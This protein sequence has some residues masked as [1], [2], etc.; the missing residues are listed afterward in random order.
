MP[1]QQPQVDWSK[2]KPVAAPDVDWSKAAPVNASPESHPPGYETMRDIVQGIPHALVGAGK[3][4]H[5]TISSADEFMRAHAPAFMTN[6]WF[7]FGKPT[8]IAKERE[9]EKPEG[10]AQNIGYGGEQAA[11]FLAPGGLEEKGAVKLAE[12]APKL[13]KVAKPLARM[14]TSG[15]GSGAVNTAQGGSPTTGALL[16]AGGTGA[17][18]L[19]HAAAP[20]LTGIAQGLKPEAFG[21]TGKAILNETSGV[22]PGS[23]RKSAR[24]VLDKLNPELDAAARAASVRPNPVKALL[25]A[26]AKEIPLGDP[27]IRDTPGE[28]IPAAP[29]P[30]ANIVGGSSPRVAAQLGST[31]ATIPPR[32]TRDDAFMHSGVRPPI[33]LPTS[34]PGVLIRPFEAPTNAAGIPPTIP[35]ANISLA[36]P[37][38]VANEALVKAG[39]G[40]AENPFG[41]NER[42]MYKGVGKMAK[43]LETDVRGEPIPENITPF[44]ALQLKR[45]I[46]K[47]QPKG[48]WSPESA[49]AFKGPRTTIYKALNDEF[50]NAVPEAAPLNRRI[51]ALIPATKPA[52][53]FLYGHALGPGAGAILGGLHGYRRAGLPG[54]LEEGAGGAAAGLLVPGA[55]NTAARIGYSPALQRAMVPAAMGT[56]LQADRKKK[57]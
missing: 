20:T 57:E 49:N 24:G 17:G 46:G 37:R 50:E 44:Q 12:L 26:P 8:N 52:A 10:T 40:T 21:K 16:G 7:G 47:A 4:L 6:E 18:E 53:N 35:N 29:L 23:I 14:I 28:L 27:F 15:I 42:K 3:G 22:L 30:R 5:H 51:S 32:L 19:L 13:G 31:E 34:G 48:S 36:K 33:E 2:A 1:P 55:M 11:E 41:E 45:G 56:I 25:P 9:Y 43:M 39:G 38:S 54:A